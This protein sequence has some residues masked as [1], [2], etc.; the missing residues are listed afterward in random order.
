M[1]PSVRYEFLDLR[2]AADSF[3]DDV[4]NGLSAARKSIPPKYFYDE[5]G[6]RLFEDICALPEYYLTRTEIGLM[7]AQARAMRERIGAGAAIV[8]YGSGSGIKTEILL[9]SAAP[10][11]YVAIDISREQLH[12]AVARLSE[13]MPAIRML[14]VCADYM[15][16][17]PLDGFAA[18]VPRRVVFFPGSTIGNFSVPEA[19]AFMRNAREVA[20][21]AGAMLVGVDLK[22][23]PEKLYA[24]YNDAAGV[25]AAFN[26]N[27]LHRINRELG[28]NFDVSAYVHGAHYDAQHGRV[29]MHLISTRAQ[30]V[31]LS[32][33]TYRLA[34]GET[35]HTE[36]SYKYSVAEFQALAAEAGLEPAECWVDADQLFSIHY[37]E[38]AA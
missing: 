33:R 9:E 5:R 6:S 18:D 35:I 23:D 1:R 2:P 15:H 34:P 22:K 37:L 20:G 4:A 30:Q 25:T 31:T 14:A 29:E 36:S 7:R 26:L 32:G 28:A 19:L 16:A 38:V 8:E 13:G 27:L 11:A 10:S 12:S 17:I 3:L 21:P 24:A